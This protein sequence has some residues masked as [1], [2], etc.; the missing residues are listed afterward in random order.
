MRVG[1]WGCD[2]R[3]PNHRGRQVPAVPEA[4]QI[5]RYI[6]LIELL[7]G[8]VTLKAH[9]EAFT[10]LSVNQRTE[11]LD[12]LRP[13]A[14]ET[15]RDAASE[16]PDVLA[17]LV[18]DA[19]P[20]DAMMHSAIAGLVA[21][22]F[23]HSAPVAAYFTVGVGSVTIDDQPPWVSELAQHESVPKDAGTMNHY[24]GPDLGI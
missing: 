12:R 1:M 3:K 23:V 15:E 9:A 14:P 13:F 4:V 22:Q 7:P 18:R 19:E 21:S 2:M 11:L 6:H 16:G 10:E 5:A 20:R 8:I 24:T 17:T